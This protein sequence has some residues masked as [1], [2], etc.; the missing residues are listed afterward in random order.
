MAGLRGHAALECIKKVNQ[1][2][3]ALNCILNRLIEIE[4]S[5]ETHFQ[6]GGPCFT[7]IMQPA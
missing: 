3:K 5:F 6:G 7:T 4:V 1:W 2:D